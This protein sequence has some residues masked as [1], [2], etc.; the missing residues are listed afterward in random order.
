MMV[1]QANFRVLAFS[2]VGLAH[3]L[4]IDMSMFQEV[5]N[6]SIPLHT[7]FYRYYSLQNSYEFVLRILQFI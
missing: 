2:Q 7:K 6:L 3:C 4:K 5:D 1:N